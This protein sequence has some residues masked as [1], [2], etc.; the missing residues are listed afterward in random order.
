MNL[1]INVLNSANGDKIMITIN[2]KRIVKEFTQDAY[3]YLIE[4]ESNFKE[5]ESLEEAKAIIEDVQKTLAGEVVSSITKI[6]QYLVHN[7]KDNKFYLA[8]GD[9][10]SSW[11][12]PDAFAQRI[13]KTHEKN[14]DVKPLVKAWIRL[15]RNPN[16]NENFINR[17]CD[18]VNSKFLDLVQYN[19]LVESGINE[20]TAKEMATCYDVAITT[21]GLLATN[22][23]ARI[24]YTKFDKETGERKDR[25]DFEFDE[26]TGVKMTKLPENLEDYTLEPPVMGQGGDE[27][28]CGDS[29]GHH[30]AVGKVHR[31]PSWSHVDKHNDH[32]SKGLW[33]GGLSYIQGYG[34]RTEVLLQCFVDPAKIGSFYKGGEF[35]AIKV[36]EYFVHSAVDIPN[37]ALYNESTYA[38]QTEQ[39]WN[40]DAMEAIKRIDEM[41]AKLDADRNEV[42][43]LTTDI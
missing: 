16:L 42:G 27:F 28:Y 14:L 7:K 41:K 19:E 11:A 8:L 38:E 6:N 36:L 24:V 25:Y 9:V 5:A 13:I 3:D 26:T 29:L 40:R 22:K 39:D 12:M 32:M 17:F 1:V 43:S 31:L 23:Y 20:E 21:S 4:Q 10:I 35:S 37:K 30:I 15:L 2:G 18:Y 33:L 34:G